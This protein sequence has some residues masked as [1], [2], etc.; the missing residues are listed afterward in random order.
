LTIAQQQRQRICGERGRDRGVRKERGSG[1]K[2]KGLS[3]AQDAEGIA[4]GTNCVALRRSAAVGR[5]G[6]SG[7]DGD[8]CESDDDDGNEAADAGTVATAGASAADGIITPVE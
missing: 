4:T 1:S 6:R 7:T 5:S 2:N 8:G 3:V